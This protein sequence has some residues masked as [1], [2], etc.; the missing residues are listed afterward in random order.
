MFKNYLTPI[1]GHPTI[2]YSDNGSHFVNEKIS[3][4]FAERSVTQ[5]TGPISHQ[6]SMG[7]M[8]REV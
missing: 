3:Q 8:E 4:Y 1:F 2:A 5:F 6:S 7:L